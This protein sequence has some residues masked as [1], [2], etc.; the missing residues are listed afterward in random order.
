MEI[1]LIIQGAWHPRTLEALPAYR[2]LFDDIVLSCWEDNEIPHIPGITA[3]K[4]RH[5]NP[6]NFN[7]G[8]IL[9]QAI[10]SLNG[11]RLAAHDFAIKVR[12]DE[13]FENLKPVI[14]KVLANPGK[15]TCTNVFYKS[16]GHYPG[17]IGD[18]LMGSNVRNLIGM[19]E[20]VV[21]FCKL[22]KNREDAIPGV[23]AGYP[24]FDLMATESIMFVKWLEYNGVAFD[25]N[26][27]RAQMIG[28]TDMVPVR[29]LGNFIVRSNNA[30]RDFRD[31]NE[32]VAMGSIRNLSE[33]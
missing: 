13:L 4:S 2:V 21:K 30:A 18:H 17:H 6:E 16:D 25:K 3:V 5:P 15:I 31:E 8:N 14:D 27:W 28:F 20:G 9:R 23:E 24:D 7:R 29:E 33:L 11:L 12:T 22:H 32:L 10:S 19:Y 26:N 1:S